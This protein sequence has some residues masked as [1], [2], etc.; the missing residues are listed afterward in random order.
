[1]SINFE[2][3]AQNS[4]NSF[5]S[6]CKKIHSVEPCKVEH[7]CTVFLLDGLDLYGFPGRGGVDGHLLELGVVEVGEDAPDVLVNLQAFQQ[8]RLAGDTQTSMH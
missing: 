7:T 8:G 1:M 4:A 3:S 5:T 6:Y 2:S